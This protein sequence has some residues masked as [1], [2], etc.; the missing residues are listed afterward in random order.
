MDDLLTRVHTEADQCRND[1]ADDIARLLD[2]VAAAL[3]APSPCHFALDN[4]GKL[5]RRYTTP[6]CGGC[7]SSAAQELPPAYML[8][9]LQMVVPLFQEAR[10]ALTAITEAQRK[11]RG[12]SPTLA[13]RM[14]AAGTFSLD[15]WKATHANQA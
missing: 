7:T 12:I 15:D 4:S 10:D 14:D 8:A 2:E 5:Y 13:D 9:K 3:K 1:G 11:A 6:Q